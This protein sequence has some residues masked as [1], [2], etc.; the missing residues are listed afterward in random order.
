MTSTLAHIVCTSL[1]AAESEKRKRL[2]FYSSV[3]ITMSKE[4]LSA[5]TSNKAKLAHMLP[6]VWHARP[7]VFAHT[8]VEG[9]L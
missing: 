5:L 3:H 9:K 8:N 7:C 6:I 2:Y 1:Y 4:F